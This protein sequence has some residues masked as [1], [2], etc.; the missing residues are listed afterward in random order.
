MQQIKRNFK[1]AAN[2]FHRKF[3][4]FFFVYTI[5]SIY[6]KWDI[7]AYNW[8]LQVWTAG[9]SHS[10]CFA[11]E[12]HSFR[13]LLNC[14]YFFCGFQK[15]KTKGMGSQ[16][17]KLLQNGLCFYTYFKNNIE[18]IEI[19]I[20]L[21]FFFL[22]KFGWFATFFVTF[23]YTY[24]LQFSMTFS[25]WFYLRKNIHIYTF[26]CICQSAVGSFVVFHFAFTE[27]IKENI[28]F[29]FSYRI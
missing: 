28:Y 16:K 7:G 10:C 9:T 18:I 2:T 4:N 6:G 23:Q 15:N 22:L 29:Y 26:F 8:I 24:K 5:V 20:K 17:I 1:S 13:W 3:S 25:L 19:Q 27:N 21:L 12:M 11:I 14:F